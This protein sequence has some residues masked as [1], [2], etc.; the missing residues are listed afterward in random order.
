LRDKLGLLQVDQDVV[1]G[2]LDV[3]WG[4]LEFGFTIP[5]YCMYQG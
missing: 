1:W 3:V 2:D 5:G 4:D